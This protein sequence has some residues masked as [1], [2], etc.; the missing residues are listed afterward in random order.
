M[1][2]LQNS[3]YPAK[4]APVYEDYDFSMKVIFTILFAL[5]L[6]FVEKAVSG[7]GEAKSRKHSRT[8]FPKLDFN[9]KQRCRYKYPRKRKLEQ[10]GPLALLFTL[11]VNLQETEKK[12]CS[13]A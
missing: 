3:E 9:Y 7:L 8:P 4:I 1:P 2:T 6:P 13:F 12:M 5:V 11:P 10:N